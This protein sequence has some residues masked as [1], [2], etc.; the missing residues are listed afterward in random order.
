MRFKK[1]VRHNYSLEFFDNAILSG[2]QQPI[3]L[4][5]IPTELE[6]KILAR[7]WLQAQYLRTSK[8]AY[9]KYRSHC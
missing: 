8:K 6:P 2:A 5:L 1:S 7:T 3:T 9:F 4:L